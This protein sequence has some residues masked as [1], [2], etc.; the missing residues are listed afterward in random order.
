MNRK[1]ITAVFTEIYNKT[2]GEAYGYILAMTG[3]AKQAP[4]LLKECYILFYAQI[5]KNNNQDHR[6]TLFKIIK[7]KLSQYNEAVPQ[8]EMPKPT[9]IKKFNDFIAAELE[10]E[11]PVPSS[12]D[13]LL[14]T[15][16]LA[17]TEVSG[18]PTVQRRAFLLYYLYDFPI[19]RVADELGITEMI[20]GN[21]IHEITET[22]RAALQANYVENER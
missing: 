11:F 1:Q 16:D 8:T 12:Q 4:L 22:I 18:T 10:T 19:E 2:F 14:Q 21:Y 20:A 15:L 9:R 17:L 6:A 13:E 7:K 5:K 3:D